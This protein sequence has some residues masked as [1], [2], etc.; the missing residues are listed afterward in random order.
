MEFRP[1]SDYS[2]AQLQSAIRCVRSQHDW[3]M[4]AEAYDRVLS[5]RHR[6][7]QL[8]AELVLQVQATDPYTTEAD[9]RF[10]E[11]NG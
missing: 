5:E 3:A 1:Y 7:D 10:F 9:I 6:L 11:N 2:I 4:G 8:F